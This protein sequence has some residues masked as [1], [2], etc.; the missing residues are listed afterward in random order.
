MCIQ[1]DRDNRTLKISQP[2]HVEDLLAKTNMIDVNTRTVPL[3]SSADLTA[4]KEG[5]QQLDKRTPYAECVGALLYIASV[6]RPDLSL[7]VSVLARHMSNPCERHW[8]LLKGVLRYLAGTKELGITYG[9]SAKQLEV[10]TDAD[11]AACKDT[12]RSRGGYLFNL[13]GGA[14]SWSSKLQSVVATS[15]AES[16][17]IAA[18]HCAREAVWLRRVCAFLNIKHKGP[19]TVNADNK[20][21]IF[22]ATNS[23]DTSRTKHIDVANHYVRNVAQRGIIKLEYINTA[24]NAAD[25]FTKPLPEAKFNKFRDIIGMS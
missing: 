7:A 15:S 2:K 13:Y 25:I 22:M 9:T 19:L 5:D 8:T 16:E 23:A 12:R 17:Y 24:N 4:T 18:A 3:S 14:I 20:A 10:W 6:S 1:R 11:Y 21:A